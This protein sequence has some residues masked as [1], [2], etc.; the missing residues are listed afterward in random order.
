MKRKPL[1]K[2]LTL[3]KETVADIGND[4]LKIVGGGT[5]GGCDTSFR[6]YC[7]PP[8]TEEVTLCGTCETDCGTCVGE[9]CRIS[10]CSVGGTCLTC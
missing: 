10:P 1:N 8:P 5:I 7:C 6:Y 3:N 9:S 4:A 2:K